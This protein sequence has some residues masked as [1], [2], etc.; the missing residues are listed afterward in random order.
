MHI[1]VPICICVHICAYTHAYMNICVHIC[2][3]A[4]IYAYMHHGCIYAHMRAY[5]HIGA[6]IYAHMR[7]YIY[8]YICIYIYIYICLFGSR[9]TILHLY[10]SNTNATWHSAASTICDSALSNFNRFPPRSITANLCHQTRQEPP[11]HR[12]PS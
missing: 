8:I 9:H 7:A 11:L 6:H 5:M 3:Y 4:S 2:I 12:L 10:L 1:C